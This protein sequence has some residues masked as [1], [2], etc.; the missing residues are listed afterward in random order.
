MPH[1]PHREIERR[2]RDLVETSVEAEGYDLVAVILT[3]S[4]GRR[5]LRL[6]IDRPGGVGMRDC[7]RISRLLSPVLDVEDPVPG[8]YHLEVSSPGMDRPVQRLADFERFAGLQIKLRL[9]AGSGRKRARGKLCGVQGQDVLV[10]V[11]GQV[12]HHPL[13]HIERATLAL[14]MEEYRELAGLGPLGGERRTNKKQQ[15]P[16]QAAPG[17][18]AVSDGNAQENPDAQ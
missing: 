9:A 3:T 14:S 10:R 17:Q 4:S 8:R 16:Q 11:D 5:A 18:A 13:D 6:C 1:L 15:E 12:V 7:A 2:V